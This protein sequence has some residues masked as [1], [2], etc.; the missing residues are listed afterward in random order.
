MTKSEI[1]AEPKKQEIIVTRIFDA[2]RELVFRMYTDAKAIPKWWGPKYLTTVVE[3]LEVRKG[4]IWR[5][6]QYDAEG[7]EHA[8]NGVYHDCIPP[9]KLVRTYEYEGNPGNVMLETVT[10]EELPEGSTKLTAHT[11]F[12]TLEARDWMLQNGAEKGVSE[13]MDRLAELLA[14]FKSVRSKGSEMK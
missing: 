2:S 9:V 5:F 8:F 13:G 11:I 7:N 14:N 4:G 1:I 12:Q 6:I 10:L 3:K